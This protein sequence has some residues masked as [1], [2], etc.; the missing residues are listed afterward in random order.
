MKPSLKYLLWSVMLFAMPAILLTAL[1]E[2]PAVAVS[3]DRIEAPSSIFMDSNASGLTAVN[4]SAVAWADYDGDGHLDFVLTGQS[5]SGPIAKVY[6]KNLDN[7]Y[8]PVADLIG[9]SRG[10]V[11]WGDYNNDNQPDIV[12]TGVTTTTQRVTKIYCNCGGAFTDIGAALPGVSDGSVAWGDYDNDGK[13]DIL[14]AGEADAGPITRIYHNNGDGSFTES[15]N[16]AGISQGLAAWGDYNNDG[17][18]DI[19]L[20]GSGLSRIYRNDGNGVFFDISAPL[21]RLDGSKAAAAAWGDYN[22]DGKLDLVLTGLNDQSEATEKVYR[23]LGND[24]FSDTLAALGGST[25]WWGAAWGDYNNDGQLDILMNGDVLSSTLKVYRN[26]GNDIFSPVD[27]GLPAITNGGS[28]AWGDYNGDS[29]LDILVTG[30][31]TGRLAKVYANTS[32][33]SNA[34]PSPPTGLTATVISHTVT[35]HWNAVSGDETPPAGLT[36]NLRVGTT[37]GGV[38]IVSPLAITDTGLRKIPAV[39][40]QYHMTTTALSNLPR[41]AYYWSVQAIDNAFA[42]SPFATE[43]TFIIPYYNRLPLVMNNYTTYFEGPWESEPNN[44]TDEA[45]GP[46]RSGQPY[47]GYPNDQKDYFSFYV[48]NPGTISMTLTNDTGQGVQLQLR[49][50]DTFL[51]YSYAPPFHIEY[52]VDQP[53]WYYAFIFNESGWNST[54]PYTLTG[55]YPQ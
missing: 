15:V 5:A 52:A 43:A 51:T 55:A 21:F 49:Y 18:L 30:Q 7:S 1:S 50:G 13:Q 37:P 4:N 31:S 2:R 42:G 38:D 24:V 48:R 25:T 39:G 46:I 14:I 20:T 44:S 45:N 11:A 10:A 12:L 26:D 40:N 17:R 6:R 32:P 47:Y 8:T 3:L 54:T 9:V 23:N 27:A 29:K 33:I 19:V 34:V 28:V 41:G 35:L 36:Y 53:G 22:N 16:L